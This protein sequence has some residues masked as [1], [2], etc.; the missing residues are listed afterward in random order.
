MGKFALVIGVLFQLNLMASDINIGTFEATYASREKVEEFSIIQYGVVALEN[1]FSD[2]ANR[3]ECVSQL[4]NQMIENVLPS[5][6]SNVEKEIISLDSENENFSVLVNYKSGELDYQL[7]INM[8]AYLS[9]DYDN[10]TAA[11]ECSFSNENT[12]NGE[13]VATIQLRNNQ[14]PIIGSIE[15]K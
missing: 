12:R 15:V 8:S 13:S 2:K 14:A 4:S 3:E 6:A 1:E 10:N 7:K 5:S 11:F 9:V